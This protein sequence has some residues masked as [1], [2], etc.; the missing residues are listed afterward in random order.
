[1][2]QKSTLGG[3]NGAQQGLKLKLA[4][5]FGAEFHTVFFSRSPSTKSYLRKFHYF[6]DNKFLEL[7]RRAQKQGHFTDNSIVFIKKMKPEVLHKHEKPSN[8][9]C[10]DLLQF[11]HCNWGAYY[12]VYFPSS[13]VWGGV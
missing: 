10:K 9:N 11:V 4:A 8:N 13:A 1:M 3:L 5:K 7:E 12:I 6:T 2:K